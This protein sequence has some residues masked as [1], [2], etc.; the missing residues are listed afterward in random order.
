MSRI[1]NRFGSEL[2]V[3]SNIR[4]SEPFQNRFRIT[5]SEPKM[6]RLNFRLLLYPLIPEFPDKLKSKRKL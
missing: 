1:M 6:L 5:G 3:N 2:F 4:G